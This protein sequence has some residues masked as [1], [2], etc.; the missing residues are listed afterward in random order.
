[1]RVLT[2]FPSSVGTLERLGA[3]AMRFLADL[4]TRSAVDSDGSFWFQ[5]F[6]LGVPRKL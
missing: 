3:L 6:V 1:M 5:R 2:C 4:E